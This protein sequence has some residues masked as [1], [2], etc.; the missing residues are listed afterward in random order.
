MSA[1]ETDSFSDWL[2]KVHEIIRRCEK[3][4]EMHASDSDWDWLRNVYAIIMRC[5]GK[6]H[7]GE[8]VVKKDGMWVHAWKHLKQETVVELVKLW[9]ERRFCHETVLDLCNRIEF[10]VK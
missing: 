7:S 10:R 4:I 3:R 5:E 8:P 9:L 6:S 1:S 2:S